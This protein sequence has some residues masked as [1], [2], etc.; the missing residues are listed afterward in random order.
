M[1]QALQIKLREV[2]REDLGG[3][4]SVGVGANAEQFPEEKYQ[5]TISFGSD[6]DRV[7]EL[8]GVVFEQIDSLRTHGLAQSYIDKT[9]AQRVRRREVQLKENSWWVGALNSVDWNGIDPRVLVRY[10]EMVDS[11]SVEKVQAAAQRYFDLE[12]YARFVLMP[13]PQAVPAAE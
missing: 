1:G 3:T 6:P 12:D 10:P 9:K 8:T 4:Y 7:D 13:D 11:L 2:L 5:I